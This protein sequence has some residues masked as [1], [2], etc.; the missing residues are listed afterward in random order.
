MYQT[1]FWDRNLKPGAGLKLFKFKTGWWFQFP[2][3]GQNIFFIWNLLRQLRLFICLIH[4][5][6]GRISLPGF[7]WGH[8]GRLLFTFSTCSLTV[9]YNLHFILSLDDYNRLVT[10]CNGT[11]EG[12][13]RRN[14]RG[15]LNEQLPTMEDIRNC[16][17]LQEF[18][19]PP[20]FRNSN[21]SF[22]FVLWFLKLVLPRKRLLFTCL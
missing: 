3:N 2:M 7:K 13:L 5:S 20:F 14:P 17:S 6:V 10:L 1:P 11:N 12:L 21:F 19:S 16:L 18:D 15:R 22:R 9:L 4:T 8:S